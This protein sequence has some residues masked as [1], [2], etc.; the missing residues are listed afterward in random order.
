MKIVIDGRMLAWTGIGRYT[1]ELIQNLAKI[2]KDNDYTVLLDPKD[3]DKLGALPTNFEKRVVN[4]RP[5]GLQEQLVLPFI[6]YKLRPDL[7]HFVHFTA[8]PLYFGKRA[9]TVHDLTLVRYKTHRGTGFKRLVFELKYWIM[10]FLLRC[11]VMRA[12]AVL[13]DTEWVKRDILSFYRHSV[14]RKLLEGKITATL[15]S[16]SSSATQI[17]ASK[18]SIKIDEPFLLYVGNYYPNKNIFTLLSVFERLRA[19]RPKLRL[20][21]VGPKDYFLEQ[22]KLQIT[23]MGLNDSVTVTGWI[24]DAD[25]AWLYKKAALFVF[26]SLS[27]G[28]GMPPLEAMAAGTPVISS[29]ST[30]LP[31]VLGDA[32][33][34]LDPTDPQDM[35]TK[36]DALLKNDKELGRLRKAGYER[37]KLFSWHRTAKQTLDV[38]RKVL[39]ANNE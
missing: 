3:A 29:D 7:V 11:S 17:D 9:V 33:A 18:A 1:S 25:L 5:Y 31:E 13:T 6:L 15:L 36:I 30:C 14:F 10:R 19:A 12:D 37:V 4:I 16:I 24:T 32:A 39:F 38:Y 34:Y 35:E 28:F 2:D 21:L 23:K 26:P 8:P 20:V 27:E 22:A